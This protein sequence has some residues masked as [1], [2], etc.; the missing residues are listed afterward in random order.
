VTENIGLQEGQL[1]S[2]TNILIY[3][4]F[5]WVFRTIKCTKALG[6]WGFATDPT[7]KAYSTPQDPV[8]HH[9]WVRQNI[10]PVVINS[11][12]TFLSNSQQLGAIKNKTARPTTF[13]SRST[14]L[15]IWS[16]LSPVQDKT[17]YSSTSSLSWCS[18]LFNPHRI[19]IPT[20]LSPAL[21]LLQPGSTHWVA[22]TDLWLYK[23]V[24][25][26]WYGLPAA[27]WRPL[28]GF[29]NTTLPA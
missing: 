27:N 26:N 7:G 21:L 9:S 25:T 17:C 14:S 4:T 1:K 12:L 2:Y 29:N 22:H 15:Y 20:L 23:A 6:G 19:N 16:Y 13:H 10:G 11:N 28:D 24:H 5:I 3:H 18:H 8:V